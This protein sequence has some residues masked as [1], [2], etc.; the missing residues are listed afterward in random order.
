MLMFLAS[1]LDQ[2]YPALEHIQKGRVH[3]ARFGLATAM[4]DFKNGPE[5]SERPE[6]GGASRSKYSSLRNG[7]FPGLGGQK[8]SGSLPPQDRQAGNIACASKRPSAPARMLS[9]A[10]SKSARS[11]MRLSRSRKNRIAHIC[12]WGEDAWCRPAFRHSKLHARGWHHQI[13]NGPCEVS[14]ASIG[15]GRNIKG[16]FRKRGAES[17]MS[18]RE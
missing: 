18:A 7:R 8:W 14:L 13:E 15:R 5:I 2:I 6:L 11:R 12:F 4:S 9:M 3:D 16:P 10:R 17:R 1:V